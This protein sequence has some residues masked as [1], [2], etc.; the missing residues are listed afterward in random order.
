MGIDKK[1]LYVSDRHIYPIEARP[2]TNDYIV[3]EKMY[4]KDEVIA[5]LT[6]IQAEFEEEKQDTKHLHYDDL[7]N[8]ESYNK[9]IDNCIDTV[10]AGIVKLRRDVDA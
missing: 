9:G 4:T 5:I 3:E 1:I 2:Y 7:E 6:E 8:A 10:Y